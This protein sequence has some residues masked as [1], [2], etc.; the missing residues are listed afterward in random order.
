MRKT[1]FSLLS[2]LIFF[3]SSFAYQEKGII[4]PAYF[5]D[6][7]IWERLFD[8]K[9]ENVEFI[10]IVNP[11]SGPGDA[12]DP[13]YVDIVNRLS[14]EGM[15]GIG[16]VH[17]SW[18]SRDIN[19]VKEEIDR[20]ISFYPEIQGFFLD[21][22][23]IDRADLDYYTELY[24]YIKSK[25]NYMI[26]LNPGTKPDLSY[27][28]ISDYIV[29]YESPYTEFTGCQADVPEQSACIVYDVP[30]SQ[31]QEIIQNEDVKLLYITD[32][33]GI[34]PY[35]TLPSY[36]EKEVS[37]LAGDY[38]DTE[39][40]LFSY[41]PAKGIII[42]AYFYDEN[43]WERLLSQDIY[44]VE[45]IVIVNPASGPGNRP[46]PH[47]QNIIQKL[48]EKGM[49]PVG[50]IYTEYGRKSIG[51]VKR[52]IRKWLKF[53]P[54]IQGFFIDQA[55]TSRR[56]VSY[57]RNLYRYIKRKGN[58]IVILSPGAPTHKRYYR[59][60]DYIITSVSPYYEN[61][62]ETQYPE[63]EGCIIY[64]ASYEDML[65]ILYNKSASLVYITDDWDY[66]PFDSLPSYLEEEIE[67]IRE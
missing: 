10:V 60:A 61:A 34:N 29:T 63:K 17:T 6:S 37:L 28:F 54:E 3:I 24:E 59:F 41:T 51:K 52:E 30:E 7:Q 19:I 46:D 57:Y 67:F 13:H 26:V 2:F 40:Y 66:N 55:A 20:W 47:Y 48:N 65:N 35:D 49:I 15:T 11:A 64:G 14:A 44:G 39:G 43:L 33:S 36:Y 42:P 27:Y 62:C 18:G 32:D 50:Y 38:N 21:E 31:L 1:I 23:S 25:G 53:Y 56:K 5:Y 12:Q 22:A 4:I 8:G 58:Y 16:Y 9:N 45:T